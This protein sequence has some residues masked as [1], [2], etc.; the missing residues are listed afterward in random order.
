MGGGGGGGKAERHFSFAH[1]RTAVFSLL[2][3]K[4]SPLNVQEREERLLAQLTGGFQHVQKNKNCWWFCVSS[5]A[6]KSWGDQNIFYAN[7]LSSQRTFDV[8]GGS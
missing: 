7:I 3:A 4:H 2:N 6:W 8:A 5:A 1:L